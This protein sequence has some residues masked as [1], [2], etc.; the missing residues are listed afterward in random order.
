MTTWQRLGRDELR[1]AID[2]A[3]PE[4][5]HPAQWV[6]E[7]GHFAIGCLKSGGEA[8]LARDV[9]YQVRHPCGRAPGHV[10]HVPHLGTVVVWL[11]PERCCSSASVSR[12]GSSAPPTLARRPGEQLVPCCAA[13]A[14]HGVHLCHC[15]GAHNAHHPNHPEFLLPVPLSP[16]QLYA[17]LTRGPGAAPED[18][19]IGQRE[20]NAA[21]ITVNGACEASAMDGGSPVSVPGA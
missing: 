16:R 18:R 11:W 20:A 6:P 9:A 2:A 5:A 4:V 3:W 15:S 13:P 7:Q 12:P 8:F 17:C 19:D 1:R 14:P 21:C 10:P